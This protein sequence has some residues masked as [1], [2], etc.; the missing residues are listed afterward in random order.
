MTDAKGEHNAVSG[1]YGQT[2]YIIDLD[3][4]QKDLPFKK[5]NASDYQLGGIRDNQGKLTHNQVLVINNVFSGG[6]A[7]DGVVSYGTT[8][9]EIPIPSDTWDILEHSKPG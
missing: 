2:L 9:K 4:F 3:H 7:F 5:V 6:R 1:H 8:A